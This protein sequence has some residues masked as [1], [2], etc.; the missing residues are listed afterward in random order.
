MLTLHRAERADTLAAALADLL[1][2]PLAD[3]FA[4]ELVAVPAKG[5]SGG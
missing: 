2:V 5:S 1:A 3:P 4:R